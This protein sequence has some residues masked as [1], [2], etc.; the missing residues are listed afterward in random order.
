MPVLWMQAMMVVCCNYSARGH[1]AVTIPVIES[2][3]KLLARITLVI[4]L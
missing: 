3:L 2:I 1:S 4:P